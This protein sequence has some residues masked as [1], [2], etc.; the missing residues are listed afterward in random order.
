MVGG[1]PLT[2]QYA[3]SIGADGFADNAAAAVTLAR[4]LLAQ[5]AEASR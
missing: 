2:P 4:R 1:A 3:Q 5:S